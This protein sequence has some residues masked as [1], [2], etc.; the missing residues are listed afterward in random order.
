MPLLYHV[1][2]SHSSADKPAVETVARQLK[3]KGLKPFLDRW[4]LVPGEPWQ[5]ALEEALDQSATCAVFIG[6]GKSGPWH[7]EEMRAALDQRARNESFRVIRSLLPG[8]PQPSLTELPRFLK[9]LTWVDFRLGLDDA[10]A[11]HSLVSGI[12]GAPPGGESV[13]DAA[14]TTLA[15]LPLQESPSPGPLPAGSRMPLSSNPLFVGR[16]EDLRTLARQLKAGETSAVGQVEV[17]AATGLGGIGKTQLASEFVYRYG[18]FFAG[19][20]FWMSFADAANVPTEVADCG[21]GLGHFLGIDSATLDQ[22]IRLVEEAWRSPLPRLLVFDNCED[23][24]L[25]ERWRPRSGGARVLVTSRRPDWNPILGVK[26]VPITTLPRPASIELLRLF[27]PDLAESE[28]ALDD[29]A[30]ELG[31]LPLALH[32]AGSFLKTYRGAAIGQPKIYLDSLRQKNLL[33]HPSLHGRGSG[34]SPTKHESDVGRT[35]DLS[36]E[37]LDAADPADA[38]AVGLLARAAWFAPGEP[39]PRSLLLSTIPLNTEDLSTSLLIEDSLHRLTA[40]G[41]L[42]TNDQN[43]LLM[44]RLIAAWAQGVPEGDDARIAVEEAILKAAALS[45]ETRNPAPLLQWQPHLRAA[46]NRAMQRENRTAA[47]LCDELGIHLWLAGDYLGARPYLERAIAIHEMVSGP[48]HESL[49]H[50]LNLLGVVLNQLQFDA[51]RPYLERALA[52]R[53]GVLGPEHPDTA[54]SLNDLGIRV[55]REG[56]FEGARLYH[57]RALA[58]REQ[59]LGQEHPDTARSLIN[60]GGIKHDQGDVVGARSDC[61]RALAIHEKVRGPEHPDTAAALESLGALLLH[62]GDFAGARSYLERALAIDQKVFGPEHPRTASALID[63]GAALAGEGDFASA[64]PCIERALAIQRRTLGLEHPETA[65]SISWLGDLFRRQGD[66][67]G[68]RRTFEEALA[69][70]EKVLRPGHVAVAQS[71]MD[72][73]RLYFDQKSF[74][75]ARLYLERALTIFLP[76][77]GPGHPSTKETRTYLSQLPGARRLKKQRSKRRS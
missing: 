28:P 75:R 71:L 5:E 68:A 31:D 60:L 44:H 51:A 48:E 16:E 12:N 27:R 26:T 11:L 20:V 49:A 29:I 77:L 69:I 41:L 19:G 70:R 13:V 10:G 18:R 73:G 4:H 66:V 21:P 62:Q 23:E 59:V 32:L 67:V 36:F 14:R 3:E 63:L 76:R 45:N 61:E 39:I 6:P 37:K 65:T 22:Q 25:L 46:T 72:L 47:R 30:D 9:R 56:D 42:E 54:D 24:Q 7:H 55:W 2:L 74:A 15:A 35:F 53:E 38:L 64:R 33:E 8:A 57:E 34:L 40:L 52:I 1:F 17:A 50:S 58:I 43:D